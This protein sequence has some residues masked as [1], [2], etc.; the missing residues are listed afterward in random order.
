[1][2]ARAAFEKAQKD[3]KK[4]MKELESMKTRFTK[5]HEELMQS[6]LDGTA[7]FPNPSMMNKTM[8]PSKEAIRDAQIKHRESSHKLYKALSKDFRKSNQELQDS[9]GEV[10]KEEFLDRVADLDSKTLKDF[11]EEEA[12]DWE[13]KHGQT[14][15]PK[16]PLESKSEDSQQSS[17]TP[18]KPPSNP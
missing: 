9:K 1:M 6:I 11:T 15:G 2:D 18:Q 3:Y 13:S 4:T 12:K 14:Q 7:E 16:N 8:R 5:E 17:E 10:S